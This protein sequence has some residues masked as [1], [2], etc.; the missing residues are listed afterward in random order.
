MGGQGIIPA[1][2]GLPGMRYTIQTRAADC[3]VIVVTYPDGIVC[4]LGVYS[5]RRDAAAELCLILEAV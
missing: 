5:N 4:T 2:W 1:E 3:F